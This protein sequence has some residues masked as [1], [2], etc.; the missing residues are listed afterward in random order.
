[1]ASSA[2][3]YPSKASNHATTVST[4]ESLS[5]LQTARQPTSSDDSSPDHSTSDIAADTHLARNGSDPTLHQQAVDHECSNAIRFLAVDAINKANSGHPGAPLGQAPMGYLLFAEVMNFNP[6]NPEWINRDRFVLSSGHGCMLQYALMHLAGYESV[7]MDDIKQFRQL[8]SRCPGHPENFQTVG[9]DVTTGPLGM[10]MANSVGLAVAEQHLAATYN[11]PGMELIDHYTYCIVGDGCLQE[12][13]SHEAS[14]IAG[15]LK[16]GKLIVLY[17]DNNITIEGPTD[18]SFTENISARYEAYGWHVQTVMDGNTDFVVLRKAIQAA[19]DE[20]SKPSLICVKTTIGFGCPNKA[21][22]EKI[23]GAPAGHAEV[24]A[25][26][27]CLGWERGEFE[28]P[29]SVYDIFRAH[30]QQGSEKEQQWWATLAKYKDCEPEKAAVF[31]RAVLDRNLP[32]NWQ[33]C[34]PVV[35]EQDKALASRQHSH[36]CLNAM[37]PVLPEL[38]GGSADLGPSNLT[39]MKEAK[40]FAPQSFEG[41]NMRFGVREFGMAAICNAMSLHGSGLV[42][43]CAT[44]TVFTDYMRGAIRLAALEKAGSIFVTTHD[45]VAL[46]EDGP[47]HQ[48]VETI[49]SL[50]MI[51]GLV[52]LRPA[53]GN[54][55]SG[56]YKIAVERS[57]EMVGPTLL[58]LSRQTL[59]KLSRSSAEGTERGAYEVS[60][61]ENPE[62]IFVATGSEVALALDAA[63]ALAPLR[64]RVVSMPSCELFRKQR[65]E[66]KDALLPRMTPKMSIEMS[67]T[68]AWMEFVDACVGINSFGASAP[69]PV[70]VKH[71]GFTVDNIV[72]CARQLLNGEKGTLSDGT[73]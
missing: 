36:T 37:C 3:G 20:T 65:Q 26:R 40:D 42:P 29:D 59:P 54:E 2:A 73:V 51:P 28:V 49:P 58:C 69:G 57:K 62:V 7:Q 45:S 9:I 22:S 55:T 66:Y 27:K 16:L 41:R 47:T 71:F 18:L 6:A 70:C 21:G 72:S 44:F 17:D 48:P 25:M 5:L 64:V 33:S 19:K 38:I 1:M 52:V 10:G 31:Q 53:D 8:N 35:T 60:Q 61:C 24:A 50:R 32:E 4:L 12:G 63:E 13:V 34:L 15:H 56:A 43:Y 68:Y 30:A 46:G 14:A 23:H 39:L 11:V 67:S